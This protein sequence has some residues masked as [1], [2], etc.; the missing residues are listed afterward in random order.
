M[1]IPVNQK[2]KKTPPK[3]SWLNW[4]F[5]SLP[6]DLWKKIGLDEVDCE[7]IGMI[8]RNYCNKS[9]RD[10]FPPEWCIL[11][12]SIMPRTPNPQANTTFR[13]ENTRRE[14]KKGPEVEGWKVSALESKTCEDP[15]LP[16][17]QNNM[18]KI[19]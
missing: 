2:A 4:D 6:A 13:H 14:Q 17:L 1:A 9:I 3:T 11:I 19:V 7:P 15:K 18:Y 8:R 12:Q 10:I 5:Q 16:K